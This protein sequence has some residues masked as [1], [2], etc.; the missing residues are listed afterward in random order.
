MYK[1][2]AV[3]IRSETL[4]ASASIHAARC[5][6]QYVYAVSLDELRYTRVVVVHTG[7]L[8]MHMYDVSHAAA[9]HALYE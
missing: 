2:C 8:Y 7:I 3:P 5:R 4:S 9:N 6:V 1:Q